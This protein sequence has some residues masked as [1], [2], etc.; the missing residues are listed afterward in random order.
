MKPLL[1]ICCTSYNHVKF[2]KETL[3][4]FLIQKTDFPIEIIIHDDAS[5][6][7]TVEII[8]EYAAKDPRILTILQTENQYSQKIN[9]WSHFVFPIAKGKYIA[10]CEG[11][12]YWTD[13]LKLQKQVDFLEANPDY[14]SSFHNS[15]VFYED[16]QTLEH[17]YLRANVP[18]TTTVVDLANRNYI[19]T[20]T[21]VLRNNFDLPDWYGLLPVGD[22]PL[23]L[24]QIKDKKIK[25]FEE[26]MGV[27][28]IH[29]NGVW[30]GIDKTKMINMTLNTIGPILKNNILSS[31]ATK[32]L[33]KRYDKYKFKLLKETWKRKLGLKK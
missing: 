15:K 5:T 18:E 20:N 30:T 13:P 19:R 4:G 16:T 33:K 9:P 17:D 26:E 12:D 11:D 32:V 27:Y 3:D 2:I 25:K 29:S 24:I 28:R 8:K 31:A 23:F 10:L 21:I 7:N 1:T 6:D 14:G 22:W